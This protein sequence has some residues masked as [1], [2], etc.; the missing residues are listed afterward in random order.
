MCEIKSIKCLV[1]LNN[2]TMFSHPLRKRKIGLQIFY[3][4]RYGYKEGSVMYWD[5]YRLQPSLNDP[6]MT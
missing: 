6:R 5:L 4:S 2:K 3:F 1:V